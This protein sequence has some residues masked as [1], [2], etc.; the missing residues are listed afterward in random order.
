MCSVNR[1]IPRPDFR[2]DLVPSRLLSP[3]LYL[4][5]PALWLL[6][7]PAR[8]DAGPGESGL[9]TIDNGNFAQSV[10]FAVDNRG[11]AA[12]FDHDG[13]VDNDDFLV[14]AA[15]ATGPAVRYDAAGLPSG[16]TLIPNGNGNI[17]ADFNADGSVDQSDFAI[18]QRCYSGKDK[19]ADRNCAN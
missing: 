5:L 11:A 19:P 9:L 6:P 7:A 2:P 18:F 15:C 4:L 14:F 1:M 17:A 3:V 16:C 12:D 8:A 10:V 13:D